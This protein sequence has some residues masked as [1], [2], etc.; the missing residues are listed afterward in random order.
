MG[1][2]LQ[3]R[4]EALT[5]DELEHVWKT[6]CDDEALAGIAQKVETDRWG[7]VRMSPTQAK[8]SRM[9]RRVARLLEDKLGGEALTELALITV[10][11]VKVPDIALCSEA[12]LRQHWSDIALRSA[13]EI[14]VEVVSPSNSEAE[15]RAKTEL[16]LNLG[17]REVWLVSEVYRRRPTRRVLFRLQPCDRA[18]TVDRRRVGARFGQHSPR[19]PKIDTRLA[20][21]SGGAAHA[22]DP[23][24]GSSRYSAPCS[25][26]LYAWLPATMK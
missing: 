20:Q 8:H 5:A 25:A 16:Y 23:S 7:V 6:L 26:K 2:A 13:P 9:V 4:C 18:R 15:L 22:P 12:F 19:P 21:R 17:A 1:A 10:D 14:C 11:G 24:S 3:L